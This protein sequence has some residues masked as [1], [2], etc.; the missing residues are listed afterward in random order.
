MTNPAIVLAAPM[1]A[2]CASQAVSQSPLWLQVIRATAAVAT[3][4]GVLMALYIVVIRDPRSDSAS[5]GA[6][7]GKGG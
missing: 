2:Q 4:I 5:A 7:E 3:T 6:T 1:T